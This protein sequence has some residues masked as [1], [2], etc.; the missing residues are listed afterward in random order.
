[1]FCF[2]FLGSTLFYFENMYT[3]TFQNTVRIELIHFT[4]KKKK[5]SHIVELFLS[6]SLWDRLHR[7]PGSK[8]TGKHTAKLL[9]LYFIVLYACAH[10]PF[11][12]IL[13]LQ[14]VDVI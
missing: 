10:D 9:L 1:M 3:Y 8:Y 2:L 4:K 11:Y 12:S 14:L 7:S 5:K 13:K 6:S